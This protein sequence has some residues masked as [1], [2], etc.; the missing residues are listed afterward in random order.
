VLV[1]A[2]IVLAPSHKV[3]KTWHCNIHL[4]R[5]RVAARFVAEFAL[6]HRVV[7]AWLVAEVVRKLASVSLGAVVFVVEFS[8]DLFSGFWPD[9]LSANGVGEEAVEAILA[10]AHVEMNARVVASI[11]VRLVALTRGRAFVDC[12]VLICAVILHEIQL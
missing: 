1:L 9:D 6:P 3:E 4:R 12:K 10:V 11:D 5:V 8:T 2:G 7:H